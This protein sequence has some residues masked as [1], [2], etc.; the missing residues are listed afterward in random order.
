M[1]SKKFFQ[2]LLKNNDNF[3]IRNIGIS[4]NYKKDTFNYTINFDGNSIDDF[5]YLNELFRKNGKIVYE[6]HSYDC[7]MKNCDSDNDSENTVDKENSEILDDLIENIKV[8][9]K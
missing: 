8:E 2:R 7:K 1:T 3:E 9:E 4:R 5:L 6:F